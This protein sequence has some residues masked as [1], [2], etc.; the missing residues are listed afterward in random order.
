MSLSEWKALNTYCVS[1]V[2]SSYS[3]GAPG[4]RHRGAWAASTIQP[5]NGWLNGR[6][7]MG[8][9]F[10]CG[11]GDRHHLILVSYAIK[12]SFRRLS[13]ALVSASKEKMSAWIAD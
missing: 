10:Y 11:S 2:N 7:R 12:F 8:G 5:A 1:A 9:E 4:P 13:E 3:K 6:G